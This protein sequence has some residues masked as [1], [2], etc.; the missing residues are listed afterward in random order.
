MAPDKITGH[1][2]CEHYR[3]IAR[4]VIKHRS[5]R[6]KPHVCYTLD[7]PQHREASQ[8]S[9]CDFC[10]TFTIGVACEYAKGHQ[11]CGCYDSQ[12]ND[13]MH[14]CC[15]HCSC[16]TT[17]S[18]R[19]VHA[20]ARQDCSH[21]NCLAMSCKKDGQALSERSGHSYDGTQN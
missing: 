13:S 8:D 11:I 9:A 20:R 2:F 7:F 15:I 16:D 10:A 1:A 3:S 5:H 14:T 18:Y 6:H 21:K 12:R 4:V 19:L 17:P